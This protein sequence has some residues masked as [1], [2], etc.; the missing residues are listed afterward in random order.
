MSIQCKALTPELW[1]AVEKL[2]GAN[3]ACGGCW[4]M[5]WRTQ[6]GERWEDLKG[7]RAKRR[8][9]R[10]VANGE[11]LGVLAFDG[12]EPVGWASLGPRR[13]YAKLDRA[14]SF[15]CQ[16]A[17]EVWSIPCFFVRSGQRGRGVSRA[18]LAAAEQLAQKSGART[19]EG[20][21]VRPKGDGR[22]PAAFAW[23]GTRPLFDSAGFALVGNADGGKQRV[24]KELTRKRAAASRGRRRAS[25][26]TARRKSRS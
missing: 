23:T 11:A 8:L 12:G 2:F 9:K 17:G 7:E 10:L 4:C 16:D 15:A 6:K 24:R 18:L 26:G 5:Y 3:G 22:Y 13:D 19:L 1:P 20:Y 14:P 25:S 21:P